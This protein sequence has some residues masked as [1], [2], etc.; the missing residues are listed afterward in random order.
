MTSRLRFMIFLMTV[1]LLCF[2]IC[3]CGGDASSASDSGSASSNTQAQNTLNDKEAS[4][5]ETTTPVAG[6]R[7]STLVTYIG[8]ADGLE[9]YG[10]DSVTIDASHKNDGYL[11]I[12]YT[13][14]SPKVKFQLTGPDQITYTYNLTGGFEVF[15]FT[16]GS[17]S[18]SVGI[19]EN[20]EGSSYSTL[21]TENIEVALTDETLPFLYANQYVNFSPDSAVVALGEE[22]AYTKN[23]DIEVVEAVYNYIISN[24]TYDY[25]K[26]K[27]VPKGYLPVVDDVLNAKTG[28][29]FDYASV[30]ATMLRT[31][32]IPTR[33]EVGYMQEEYHAWISIHTPEQ[34]WINGVIEFDGTNWKLMDPTFASS[35]KTPE[36]FLTEDNKYMTKYVY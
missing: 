30:M 27:T 10:N 36:S 11:M 16:S 5:T 28:I 4:K 26:A 22:L 24:F 6:T 9:T 34:G 29:C 14:S 23:N 35:S 1:S 33:L 32:N 15:P 3:A 2:T 21:F 31:Q 17:G 8:A 19:F 7:G 18:Y 12:E 25:E 20:I 13:G